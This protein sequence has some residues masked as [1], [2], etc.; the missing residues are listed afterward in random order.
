M[1][2]LTELVSGILEAEGVIDAPAIERRAVLERA[3]D[4]ASGWPLGRSGRTTWE[5][6][7]RRVE[8]RP[9]R[10][11]PTDREAAESDTGWF[12]RQMGVRDVRSL[13]VLVDA[14][15]GWQRLRALRGS[16]EGDSPWVSA[17]GFIA[18]PAEGR[19]AWQWPLRVGVLAGDDSAP[20]IAAV[21]AEGRFS[22]LYQVFE[23]SGDD[24]CEFLL[25]P[26]G[27]A[28]G[29]IRPAA[30]VVTI[31]ATPGMAGDAGGLAF[32]LGGAGT[33]ISPHP[34]RWFE[35]L[36]VELSHDLPLDLAL[37]HAERDALLMA[38]PWFVAR[39]TIRQWGRTLHDRLQDPVAAHLLE[40]VLLGEFS[41]ERTEAAA[42][43]A[44]STAAAA[45][46]I[47]VALRGSPPVA[48]MAAP[49][50]VFEVAT[51]A[52]D[53]E[54]EE[55]VTPGA[56]VLMDAAAWEP[57]VRA[58]VALESADEIAPP[59]TELDSRRLQTLVRYRLAGARR[60]T[61]T[62]RLIAGADHTVQV[63][64]ASTLRPGAQGA[65]VPFKSPDRG[66]TVRLDVSV[67][68]NGNRTKRSL[69]LPAD[70][71]SAWTRAVP[72]SVPAR[73]RNFKVHVEV[74]FRRRVIQSATLSGTP[75]VLAVDR[76]APAL[77]LDA[78][79]SADA[80]ISLVDGPRRVPRIL[81]L[82]LDAAGI[83]AE[84]VG[85]E[86]RKLREGL[87]EAFV[88]PPSDL[89]SAAASLTRLAVRG[90]TLY[91]RL[92]GVDGTYH[93]EDNW[94]HV[95]SL[96]T[97]DVPLELVYSHPMPSND[98]EVPVCAEALGGAE[99][100][101][102][103]CGSRHDAGVVC[104]FGFWATSKILERRNHVAGRLLSLPSTARRLS[105]LRSSVVGWSDK[106]NE[107][108]GTASD[109]ICIALEAAVATSA[110]ATSWADLDNE[111]REH[112]ALV[113]LVTHT[114][115]PQAGNDDIALEL[116]G[117]LREIHRINETAV[118]P[119][120]REPGPIVF[121]LGCDTSSL[122]AGFSDLVLNFHAA[123]AE[124]VVSALSPIPGKG[125]ADF[126]ERFLP[127]LVTQLS[128][129]Q[130]HRFGAALLA[131]RRATIAR[132]DL[133]GLALRATGDADVELVL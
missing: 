93:D 83:K 15:D 38:D 24:E 10:W 32:D 41:S 116:R 19:W 2:A 124:I 129:G 40:H 71:D 45:A 25:V 97:G 77:G 79:E 121:A 112:P 34:P 113:V 111:A 106:A 8:S 108:D 56:G 80:L 72:F 27:A 23:S 52:D 39:S 104:P 115:E 88:A 94:I 110:V 12:E 42:V 86:T 101:E 67:I 76:S 85:R 47:E 7:D 65:L 120:R 63:A 73:A 3:L 4:G 64:I 14:N 6:Y 33:I 20:L 18:R 26:A 54:F 98:D 95:S 68:V 66:K 48:A 102:R 100:C 31:G 89:A 123:R 5:Q 61:V 13:R 91:G 22:A 75:L 99:S 87:L 50:P 17:D 125:V 96:T 58:W 35:R 28:T 132:G 90:A 70:S 103:A 1:N 37:R 81:D 29:R 30:I 55:P 11:Q 60:A 59:A 62:D 131:A 74:A 127:A 51:A 126:L 82:D 119:G 118:N 117:D 92:A 57:R 128:D 9:V 78:R 44:A 122:E 49:A 107:G 69:S 53:E 133:M 84:Q 105:P 130:P 16:L 21:K 43:V 114:V 36:V 46:G 109:R